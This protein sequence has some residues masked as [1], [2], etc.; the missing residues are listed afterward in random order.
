MAYIRV[1]TVA[2][3]T[4]SGEFLP[5]IPICREIEDGSEVHLPLDD[6][7]VIFADRF[8]L[9]QQKRREETSNESRKMQKKAD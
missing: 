3:R 9:Y 4:P 5:S 8:R 7:A 1:G 6:L 2:Y